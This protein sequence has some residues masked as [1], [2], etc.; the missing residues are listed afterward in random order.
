MISLVDIPKKIVLASASPRRKELL[1]QMGI[2]FDIL[3]SSAEEEF[4]QEGMP[5]RT[6]S[7]YVCSLAGF[8]AED[9]ASRIKS[10]CLVIGADTVVVRRGQILGK[11]QSREEAIAMLQFLQG[12]W[13]DVLTGVAV[14]DRK[15]K[16]KDISYACTRVEMAHLTMQQIER[17]ADSGEC[18]DKAGA[19]GIQGLAAAFIPRIEGCYFNVVG[20]PVSTLYTMLL[21]YKA[22]TNIRS[23]VIEY[24]KNGNNQ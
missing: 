4:L 18:I 10:D 1:A 20:L 16:Y 21:K 3:P 19:Y 17:Y 22:F 15:L 12:G 23:G 6:P 11:P 5:E 24:S 13:H 14:I 8:K 2:S 9:V 7:D